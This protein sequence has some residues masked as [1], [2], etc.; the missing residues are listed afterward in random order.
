MTISESEDIWADYVLDAIRSQMENI[1][2]L[3]PVDFSVQV[4]KEDDLYTIMDTD[5]E[6]IDNVMIA[7]S[8]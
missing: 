3:E 7:Y 8:Y 6:N 4:V 1:G 2:Y 5:F